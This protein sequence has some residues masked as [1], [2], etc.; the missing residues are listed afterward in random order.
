MLEIPPVESPQLLDLR[1]I[2]TTGV[3]ARWPLAMML[4]VVMAVATQPSAFG[5]S[6][7]GP[8]QRRG[9]LACRLAAVLGPISQQSL[10]NALRW[11]ERWSVLRR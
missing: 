9:I 4:V 6:I 3:F 5:S 1:D 2:D 10:I 11:S 8:R 7:S